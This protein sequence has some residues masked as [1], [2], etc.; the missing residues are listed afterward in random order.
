STTSPRNKSD[1]KEQVH[2]TVSETINIEESELVIKLNKRKK[3]ESLIKNN[4]LLEDY[5]FNKHK[6]I[7]E[8]ILALQ[9]DIEYL[10]NWHLKRKFEEYQ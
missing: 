5:L 4:C 2:Q 10:E 7:H 1:N 9:E 8:D 6:H 3:I